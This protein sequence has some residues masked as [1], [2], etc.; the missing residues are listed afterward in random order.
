MRIGLD[1][2][3]G[4]WDT[5][6]RTIVIKRSQLRSLAGFAGT[7]LHEACVHATTGAPDVTRQFES[8]LTDYLGQTAQ[9]AVAGR[10]RPQ[11]ESTDVAGPSEQMNDQA[12]NRSLVEVRARQAQIDALLAELQSQPDDA[13]G[14]MAHSST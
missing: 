7:L 5:A 12:P 10:L 6:L 2:T 3:N 1:T 14:R 9:Q 8:V 11:G 13:P 4:V